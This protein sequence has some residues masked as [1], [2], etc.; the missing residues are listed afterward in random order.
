MSFFIYHNIY[1][2]ANERYYHKILI[3][4]SKLPIIPEDRNLTHAIVKI[5]IRSELTKKIVRKN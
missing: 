4:L 5:L 1:A 2:Y 3:I